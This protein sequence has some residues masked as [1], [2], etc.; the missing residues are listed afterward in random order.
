M[1]DSIDEHVAASA[2]QL[3]DL[4]PIQEA[5]VGRIHLLARHTTQ[6][7]QQALRSGDL[8]LWQLKTLLMLRKLGPPYTTSPSQLATMLN[9]T[10]GALS[11]RLATLEEM[12]LITR[13]HDDGDRRR[14][15][16]SLTPAGRE[17][18]DSTMDAEGAVEER[19]LSVLTD[20]EKRTL[21]DLLR[22]VV[23][24]VET[25]GDR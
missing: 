9:L 5:I 18:L 25:A 15:R 19:M 1:R 8:V 16:V 17:V 13:A 22:K 24:G 7:R 3:S 20:R 14:V 10:R 6:G 11:L 12:G 2:E 23:L 21:A 4:D